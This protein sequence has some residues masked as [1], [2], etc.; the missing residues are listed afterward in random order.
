MI[1]D[2]CNR[3]SMKGMNRRKPKM[4][5]FDLK[6]SA[7]S[8]SLYYVFH[9]QFWNIVDEIHRKLKILRIVFRRNLN[10]LKKSFESPQRKVKKPW[11]FFESL[12]FLRDHSN[13]KDN[14]R[15]SFRSQDKDLDT[16]YI[17]VSMS[18]ENHFNNNSW[19]HQYNI[20]IIMS[21]CGL[22]CICCAMRV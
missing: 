12:M 1:Y 21:Q 6:M 15:E 2:I 10:D 17:Q 11:K 13:L 19:V 14:H 16:P 22:V 18:L 3:C 9:K 7:A 8:I 4:K 5:P 20:N